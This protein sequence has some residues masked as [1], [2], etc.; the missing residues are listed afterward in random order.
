MK[1]VFFNRFF[2]PDTS[3]TSQ[4]LSDLAFDLARDGAQ[5]HVVTSKVP[6]GATALE[7][8]RGVPVPRV[9]SAVAGPHGLARRAL[10]YAGYY[11][12]ARRVA[13][14]ILGPGDIAVLKTDPPMLSAI[15]GPVAA[16]RGAKVAVWVQDVFPEV[17]A[18]YGVPFMDGWFGAMLRAKRNESLARADRVVAIGARMAQRLADEGV[19][20]AKLDV[21]HNWADGDAIQPLPREGNALRE[22][23]NLSGKFIVGYSGNL[24]RVHE[25]DTMLDAARKLLPRDDI[26]FV[27]VGRGPR[28]AEVARRVSR[29]SLSNVVVQPHQEREGLA[30]SLGVA[31]V[32]LSVLQPRF[33]SLVLPSKHYGIMAAGR[34]LIFIGDPAGESAELVAQAGCG[35]AVASGD[36]DALAAAIVR[37]TDDADAREAMGRRGREAFE[38]RY[39]LRNARRQWRET[40][41]SLGYSSS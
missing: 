36:G 26:R 13:R 21:I 28:L 38:R 6:G 34:P 25:F 8:I 1:I 2:F 14:S 16:R 19:P 33:D 7:T 4:I 12:G 15:V 3:A 39:N 17:A 9:A 23:W 24:G 5:V 31:D 32:H 20:R 11:R 30:E 37:L 40:L 27:I 29:E 35:M 18:L 22:R 41:A 10:A